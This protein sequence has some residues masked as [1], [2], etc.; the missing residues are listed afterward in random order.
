[1]RKFKNIKLGLVCAFIVTLLSCSGDNGVTPPPAATLRV[2][3]IAPNVLGRGSKSVVLTISGIGFTNGA[4]VDLGAGV[5]PV[6]TQVVDSAHLEVTINVNPQTASGPRTVV[7]SSAGKTAQLSAG[8]TISENSAP[9]PKFTVSPSQGTISS[10]FDLD[11][12]ASTDNDGTIKT[13]KWE[14]SDGTNPNGKIVH[15]KFSEKGT[16]T[17]RLTLTDNDG[18]TS[19][20]NAD[21]KVGDNIPPH[22]SFTIS[23][24][25]GSNL[26][27]FTLD[28]SASVDP[29]GGITQYTW[30][31]G[32]NLDFNGKVIQHKFAAGVIVVSLTV[33]DTK[34]ATSLAKKNLNVS[35]FDVQKESKAVQDVL[36]DFLRRFGEIESLSADEIVV[37]FSRNCSGRQHEINI[38]NGEKDNI[39]SS[40]VT[41]LGDPIVSSINETNARASITADFHGKFSDGTPYDGVATHHCTLIKEGGDWKICEFFVTQD[42]NALGTALPVY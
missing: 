6:A 3:S 5:I 2:D 36:I 32:G 14:I 21:L 40:G 11:A 8:L 17:V 15:K 9:V 27:T 42:S 28:A 10:T 33:R 16:Y 34:G 35:F 13:Y 38:I 29:D 4:S 1:M 41:I 20:A 23:P 39:Q 31:F 22:A 12:S 19:S 24:Q 30:N 37:G 26:T 18:S 7:V 25:T